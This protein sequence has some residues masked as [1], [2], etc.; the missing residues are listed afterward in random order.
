MGSVEQSFSVRLAHRPDLYEETEWARTAHTLP[1]VPQAQLRRLDLL[2]VATSVLL[3]SSLGEGREL[4]I[5]AKLCELGDEAF[6]PDFLRATIEMIGTE[7]LIHRP[8]LEHV[9]DRRE[10]RGS[11]RAGC[12]LWSTSAGETVELGVKVTAFLAP[13]GPGTLDQQRLKPP[14]AFSQPGGSALAGTLIIARTQPGP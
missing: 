9:V 10:E 7:I 3:S 6:G 4:G 13:G 11:D 2:L 14:V 1:A 12:L 5:E 8:V